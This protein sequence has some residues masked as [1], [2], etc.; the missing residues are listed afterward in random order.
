[1]FREQIGNHDSVFIGRVV[2]QEITGQTQSEGELRTLV[3]AFGQHWHDMPIHRFT[4]RHG[5]R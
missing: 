1:M 5:Q 2:L 4:L 3:L